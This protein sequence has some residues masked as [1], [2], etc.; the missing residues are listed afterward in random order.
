VSY[1]DWKTTEPDQAPHGFGRFT[2]YPRPTVPLSWPDPWADALREAAEWME[3]EW[4][5]QAEGQR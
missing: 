4:A 3:A 5:S 1:D 2:P